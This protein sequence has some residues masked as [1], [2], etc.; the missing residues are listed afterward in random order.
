MPRIS[1]SY[2]RIL[3]NTGLMGGVQIVQVLL[4][5]LRNK[6][7]AIFIGSFGMGLADI[8]SRMAEMVGSMTNFGISFSAIRSLSE[9]RQSP[10]F[11]AISQRVCVV[12]TWTF[13]TAL[14]GMVV[15]IILSPW[16]S[17]LTLGD[18]HTQKGFLLLSPM[19]AMLTLSGGEMSILKAMQQLKTLAKVNVAGALLTLII[20]V[21]AYMLM[22]VHG[23]LPVLLAST[24]LVF[25]LNLYA[26]SRIFPYSIKP[27]SRSVIRMGR[28]IIS[29][30]SAY[31]I[32][33]LAGSGAELAVRSVLIQRADLQTAGFFA[34]GVALIVSY[35]R[36][37]FAALDAD[38]FPRLSAIAEDCSIRN[39]TI[40]K[41]IDVLVLLLAP[42][43]IVMVVA[44]P[45]VVRLLYTEEFLCAVPM[46]LCA[47][48]YV[49]FKAVY[50]PI[51]YLPLAKGHPLTYLTMELI[52][53]AVFIVCVTVGFAQG[54]LAGA[55]IGLSLANLTDLLLITTVYSLRYN[56]RFD[57]RTVRR[58]IGQYVLLAAALL[59]VRWL[60]GWQQYIVVGAILIISLFVSITLLRRKLRVKQ[61][62]QNFRQRCSRK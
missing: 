32:A 15:C 46:I 40:N 37:I 5:I 16:L 62:I 10:D 44:A 58:A 55:G 43:L 48:S 20:S 8:Y 7:A 12:R 47:I 2:E 13:L 41:Q 42:M 34:A 56:F 29:L 36:L 14:L 22:G 38:Y 9:L 25:L 1:Y 33:G 50:S 26:T 35:S 18:T 4:A 31:V 45:I 19:V 27:F 30:G 60:S 59:C 39:S 54:G 61:W 17:L 28:A 3:K 23:I 24:G 21:P 53:D 57:R 49:F 52:Y 11:E 6:V 51:S